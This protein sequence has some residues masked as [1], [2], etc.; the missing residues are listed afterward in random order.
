[1]PVLLNLPARI[2]DRE[3]PGCRDRSRREYRGPGDSTIRRELRGEGVEVYEKGAKHGIEIF[4][5]V[6]L[7]FDQ[8]IVCLS[9]VICQPKHGNIIHVSDRRVRVELSEDRVKLIC[10]VRNDVE[11]I[12]HRHTALAHLNEAI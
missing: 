11:N 10:H 6:A 5:F 3:I 8:S 4:P 12:L 2:T 1:M 9:D 7:W